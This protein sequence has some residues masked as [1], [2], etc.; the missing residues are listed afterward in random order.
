[1]SVINT[2]KIP[3]K[4]SFV[5]YST[6]PY[7]SDVIS[8][9]DELMV[10]NGDLKEG[11]SFIDKVTHIV[12]PDR[13]HTMA[14]LPYKEKYP[15]IK[16]V[17]MEG[18]SPAIDK[19]IDYKIPDTEGNKVL[20]KDVLL[21]LGVPATSSLIKNDFQFVFIPSHANKELLMFDPTD[22]TLFEA[23]MF[24]NLQHKNFRRPESDLYNEQFDGKDPQTGVYG[25]LTRS[26]FTPNSFLG[27]F[28]T[29]SIFSDKPGAKKGLQAMIDDWDFDRI[30]V[31]HGDTIDRNGKAVWKSSFSWILDN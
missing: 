8:S 31:C 29:K 20:G 30:I 4:P 25:F 11:Q 10:K 27:G 17:G 16:V 24:F 28:L 23:D 3:G 6:I 13:E 1:M 21:K 9:I 15:T 5:I 12:V 22:K 14:L 19:V 18:C 26:L 2:S 7:D